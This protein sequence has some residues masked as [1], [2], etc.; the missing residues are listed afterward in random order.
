MRRVG[1]RIGGCVYIHRQYAAEIPGIDLAIRKAGEHLLWWEVVKW[2]TRTNDI[3]IINC[4]DFNDIPEP[5]VD[6]SVLVR[7]DG[8]TKF[9][10]AADDPWVY[11]HKW[12]MVADDFDGFDVAVAKARSKWWSALPGID[13]SRIG[14]FSHWDRACRDA[15]EMAGDRAFQHA[16]ELTRELLTDTT[17]IIACSTWDGLAGIFVSAHPGYDAVDWTH[18]WLRRNEMAM[19]LIKEV[20]PYFVE[21]PTSIRM[22]DVRCFMRENDAK[23][24]VIVRYETNYGLRFSDEITAALFR[25]NFG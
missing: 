17:E 14:K 3:T 5:H 24:L 18:Y 19:R 8:S 9:I 20:A 4:R 12:M 6:E 10:A 2:N 21:V 22:D 16:V 13:R 23:G 7:P 15:I 1:K 25:L 11:H